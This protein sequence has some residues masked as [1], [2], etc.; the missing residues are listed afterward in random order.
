MFKD[1]TYVTTATPSQ[2]SFNLPHPTNIFLLL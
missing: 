1:I 2:L